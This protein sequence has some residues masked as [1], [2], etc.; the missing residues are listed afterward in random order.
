MSKL[1]SAVL[2]R[3][4]E[5]EGSCLVYLPRSCIDQFRFLD[6]FLSRQHSYAF[7]F[8]A[9]KEGVTLLDIWCC[10][11]QDLRNMIYDGTPTTI[12]WGIDLEVKI[13]GL[14]C[15]I[16]SDGDRFGDWLLAANILK[17][18]SLANF[19]GTIEIVHVV[20]FRHLWDWELQLHA[21]VTIAGILK[22]QPSVRTLG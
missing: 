9:S 1:R 21:C 5:T 15:D 2:L 19:R 18:D 6:L 14:S 10:I 3:W 7:I 11:G 12:L 4:S 17:D 8:S 22:A 16:F 13:L 20:M